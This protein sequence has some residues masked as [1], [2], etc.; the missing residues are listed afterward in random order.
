MT[1]AKTSRPALSKAVARPR[2]FR[3]LDSAARAP[4]IWVWGPPGAGKSTLVSSYLEA[5]AIAHLWYQVDEGDGD[6]ATFFYYLG[7]AAPHRR[8]A[9]PLLTP[10]YQPDIS[11]FSRRFFRDLLGRFKS[12]YVIVLDNYQEVSAADAFHD[13][14]RHLIEETPQHGRVIVISRSEPPPILARYRVHQRM[15][16]VAWEDL[17]FTPGEAARL[18][19]ASSAARWRPVMVRSLYESADGWGA[20]LVLLAKQASSQPLRT[21]QIAPTAAEVL[22]DYFEEEILTRV[23]RNTRDVLSQTAFLPHLTATTAADLTGLREA[24]DVLARLHRRNYFTNRRADRSPV[25]EYHRLFRAFLLSHACRSYD[26]TRL[27]DIRRRAAAIAESYGLI[28]AAASLLREGE[29]WTLL[30][31]LIGRAAPQLLAQGRR[32]T[33]ERHLTLLPTSTLQASPWLLYWRGVCG[34]AWR[35][36]ESRRDLEDALRQFEQQAD[37]AGVFLAWSALVWTAEAESNLAGLDELRRQ[38]DTLALDYRTST[39]I[40]VETRVAAAMLSI[41]RSRGSHDSE[42]WAHRALELA[43]QSPDKEL[44]AITAF[45][46]FIHYFETGNHVEAVLVVNDMRTL[47]RSHDTAPEVALAASMVVVWC[48]ALTGDPAYRATAAQALQNAEALGIFHAARFGIVCGA[49]IGALG[50]GDLESARVFA[51]EFEKHQ[52]TLG[53]GYRAVYAMYQ[54][55]ASLARGDVAGA[56]ARRAEMV[57]CTEASGWLFFT[58]ATH[59]LSAQVLGGLG[60]IENARTDFNRAVEFAR[61]MQSPYVDFMV[62]LTRADLS[63]NSGQSSDSLHALRS[64][65]TL[66]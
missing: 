53:L 34:F 7:Q 52:S 21:R 16:F 41:I 61:A 23:D 59:L 66:D 13:V 62:Q 55:H 56:D 36:S 49:L 58:V 64:A 27:S 12:S 46:W 3:R 5:R 48:E 1:R 57:R 37:A 30:A 26:A 20:G 40:D 45:N 11:A 22:F 17:R 33:V 42:P 44:Y 10:A 54:M 60:D 4:V 51:G 63:L 35:H 18:L 25:Y 2:L 29:E 6:L 31:A 14:V 24:G 65:M 9:L 47:I 50:N 8:R 32:D 19:R 38:F 15:E 28:D 43:R 39:S